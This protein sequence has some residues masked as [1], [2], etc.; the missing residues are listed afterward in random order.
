VQL[1]YVQ[2]SH[3][4]VSCLVMKGHGRFFGPV[5]RAPALSRARMSCFRS[6]SAAGE[7]DVA[8]YLC[9]SDCILFGFSK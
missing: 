5:G 3:D 1:F 7:S 4:W 8:H 2:L 6:L 9:V